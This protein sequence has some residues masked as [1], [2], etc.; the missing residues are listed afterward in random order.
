MNSVLAKEPE[1]TRGCK[2]SGRAKKKEELFFSLTSPWAQRSLLDLQVVV[3]QNSHCERAKGWAGEHLPGW[4]GRPQKQCELAQANLWATDSQSWA[5]THIL[6]WGWGRGGGDRGI[7][8][9]NRMGPWGPR[10]SHLL[11]LHLS[12]CAAVTVFG[13]T[14]GVLSR[15]KAGVSGVLNTQT[16]Y[17]HGPM[18]GNGGTLAKP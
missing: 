18:C 6:C 2:P 5:Q 14:S 4:A 3:G 7:L 8:G 16:P 9:D 15:R 12:V 13:T 17:L 10:R 11:W 1:S